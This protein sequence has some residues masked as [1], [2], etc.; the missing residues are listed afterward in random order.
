MTT[1]NNSTTGTA[2]REIV[3]TRVFDAPRELVWQAMTDP[4]QVVHW[5]GP[6]GFTTTIETMDVR[7]GGA[8]KHTMHGPDGVN[9]PNKSIFQ[10]VVRPE[11]IVFSHGGG[12]EGGPGAH[13]V[14]TWTFDAEGAGRTRV[15]IRMVFPSAKDRDFVVKEFG[16]IE[17]GKQTLERLAEHLPAMGPAQRRV[18]VS[19]LFA[20]RA[21][22]VFDAWLDPAA[23]GGWLFATPGGR[24]VRVEIDARVGGTFAIVEQRGEVAVEHTGTYLEID[25]P[26]RLAF[27]F[28]V[29]QYSAETT[30]VTVEVAARGAGC[31]LTL[32]HEG[33]LPEYSERTTEGWTG[34]LAHLAA[35]LA[36]S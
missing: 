6:R 8:W 27:S 21:E 1:K 5:W 24:M 28:C 34:I 14:A 15:T 31:E 3:I 32:T 13:F 30:R 22:D 16:A 18:V 35:H 11:R 36:K 33:V 29:P 9:Y 2:D 20:A 7:P 26:R 17:G 19:R 25:R 12:R 10:E 4:Q 23:V